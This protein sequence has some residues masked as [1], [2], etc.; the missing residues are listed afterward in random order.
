LVFIT[1]KGEVLVWKAEDISSEREKKEE[2]I[3]K[4]KQMLAN[5]SKLNCYSHG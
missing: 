4:I 1:S 5:E 2:V 3:K